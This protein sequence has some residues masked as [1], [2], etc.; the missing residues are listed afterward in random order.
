VGTEHLLLGILQ[1]EEGTAVAVLWILGVDLEALSWNVEKALTAAGGIAAAFPELPF[2]PRTK[3]ILDWAANEAQAMSHKTIGTEHLLLA[4]LKD[5]DTAAAIV[6]SDAGL[7]YEKVRQ[8]I[9]D[10]GSARV[11]GSGPET[12]RPA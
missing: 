6:F 2:T 7:E 10:F 12:V 9:S 1:V 3:K 8:S 4:L 5:M 11:S